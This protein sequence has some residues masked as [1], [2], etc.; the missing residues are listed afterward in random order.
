MSKRF[1]YEGEREEDYNTPTLAEIENDMRDDTDTDEEAGN[2]AESWSKEKVKRASRI[3]HF[4]SIKD[5]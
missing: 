1:D 2:G 3:H 4:V 5:L